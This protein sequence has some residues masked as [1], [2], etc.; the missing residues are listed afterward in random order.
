VTIF[1]GTTAFSVFAVPAAARAASVDF[2]D[3]Q[4]YKIRPLI[5]ITDIALV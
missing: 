4:A 3:E 1:T 2:F 5:I